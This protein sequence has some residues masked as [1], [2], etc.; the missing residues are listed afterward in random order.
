LAT[1]YVKQATKVYTTLYKQQIS[2]VQSQIPAI[3]QLY[4]AL[5]Q[6]LMNTQKTETQNI[7]EDA[8]GKGMLMSTQPVDKRTQLAQT[9]LQQAGQYAAQQAQEISKVNQAVGDLRVNKT[10]DIQSLATTLRQGAL[11]KQKLALEKQ[12]F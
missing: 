5:N 1:K 7:L 9:I 11:D 2:A 10:R 8:S 3:N 12:R 4:T 6:G